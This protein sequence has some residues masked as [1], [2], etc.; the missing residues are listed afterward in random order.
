MSTL[1]ETIGYNLRPI[2]IA[3]D[4]I[5]GMQ[6]TRDNPQQ[7]VVYIQGVGPEGTEEWIINESIHTFRVKYDNS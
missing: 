5:I 7:T 4:K 3:K 2:F 1:I 6:E